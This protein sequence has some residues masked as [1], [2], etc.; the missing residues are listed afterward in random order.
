MVIA[1]VLTSLAHAYLLPCSFSYTL[2]LYIPPR[3]LQ[4]L[5]I[6]AIFLPGTQLI[7]W[8][9][10]ALGHSST[11]PQRSR[12]AWSFGRSTAIV[13]DAARLSAALAL[14]C[15]RRFPAIGRLM[16]NHHRTRRLFRLSAVLALPGN[17]P[18]WSLDC[19]DLPL[20]LL[21]FVCLLICLL[22]RVPRLG[23]PSS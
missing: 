20:T 1:D 17:R 11:E 18:L 8:V 15:P 4:Q 3:L 13:L 6:P 16:L 19:S 2:A 12:R 21:P 5:A 10:P 23:P 14:S 9:V 22:V 7:Y